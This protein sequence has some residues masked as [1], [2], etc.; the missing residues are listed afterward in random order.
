MERT[1]PERKRSALVKLRRLQDAGIALTRT[2]TTE[3][4]L[5]AIE[6]EL[7]L[8]QDIMHERLMERKTKDGV[9]FAR[10][11][12]LAFTS[13]TEFVNKRYDPFAVD[14]DG[15]SESVMENIS[16]YDSAFERLL[17]KYARWNRDARTQM[18]SS[19]KDTLSTRAHTTLPTGKPS[20]HD[21]DTDKGPT[22]GLDVAGPLCDNVAQWALVAIV[23]TGSFRA[24]SRLAVVNMTD[25]D[26]DVSLVNVNGKPVVTTGTSGG[27]KNVRTV[28]ACCVLQLK[29]PG[30]CTKSR[31]RPDT[32]R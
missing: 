1:E 7:K 12:L 21:A 20:R 30:T 3:D 23:S 31:C 25:F 16:D 22:I 2:F 13:F 8:Q 15:W 5:G 19:K 11:V 6:D 14:L 4:T 17:V 10:R 24:A 18:L 26:G 27:V 28:S 9:K 32:A 29:T